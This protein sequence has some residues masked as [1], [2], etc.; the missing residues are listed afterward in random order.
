MAYFD[1]PKNRAMWEKEMTVLRTERESRKS[2]GFAAPDEGRD[3]AVQD[4]GDTPQRERTSF[5]ELQLV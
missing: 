1:S 4:A 2:R 3:S 5:Q